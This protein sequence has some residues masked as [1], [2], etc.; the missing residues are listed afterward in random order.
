MDTIYSAL[1]YPDNVIAG[2]RLLPGTGGLFKRCKDHHYQHQRNVRD[3]I[4]QAASLCRNP[5]PPLDCFVIYPV[6]KPN[7]VDNTLKL[8]ISSGI[9]CALISEYGGNDKPETTILKQQSSVQSPSH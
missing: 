7:T 4:G 5:C 6:L 2:L 1:Y 3:M 8:F 9:R